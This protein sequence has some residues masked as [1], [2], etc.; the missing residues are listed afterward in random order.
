M[1]NIRKGDKVKRGIKHDGGREE[2]MDEG[3]GREQRVGKCKNREERKKGN[4]N[5]H[6]GSGANKWINKKRR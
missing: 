4:T 5:S 6:K 1:N 2:S 3:G